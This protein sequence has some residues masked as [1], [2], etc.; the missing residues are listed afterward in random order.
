MER[1]RWI[2]FIKDLE[3]QERAGL[4]EISKIPILLIHG[5]KQQG[6]SFAEPNPRHSKTALK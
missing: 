6:Q 2:R 1:G 3:E 4:L 5:L